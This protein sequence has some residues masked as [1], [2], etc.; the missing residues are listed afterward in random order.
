MCIIFLVD[1]DFKMNNT[2]KNEQ[3]K[4]FK[5]NVHMAVAADQYINALTHWGR[6]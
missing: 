1:I 2:L 3:Q 6:D 5:K 4:A